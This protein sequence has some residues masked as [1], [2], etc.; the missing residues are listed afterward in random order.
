MAFGSALQ[1]LLAIFT[2]DILPIFLIAGSG[3]VLARHSDIDVRTVARVIF[4]VLAPCL[5][6]TLIVQS[7][8]PIVEFGRM[9][10]FAVLVTAA[11]GV[12]A[13]GM[14]KIGRA[15]CRERV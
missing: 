14:A 3:F 7:T 12:A 13:F 6:F 9:A 8:V 4:N 5:V 10:L 11:A 1:T 15:S 2:A